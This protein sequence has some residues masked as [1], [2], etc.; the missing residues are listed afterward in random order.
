M[1]TLKLLKS[2]FE[3]GRFP[4]VCV[5]CGKEADQ[6][7]VVKF[8]WTP[9]WILLLWLFGL[10]PF[11]IGY[12]LTIRKMTVPLPVCGRHR[13]HWSAWQGII[14]GGIALAIAIS[15]LGAYVESHWDKTLGDNILLGG[16]CLLGLMFFAIFFISDSG[17]RPEKMTDQ[18]ITL[19]G[20]SDK[21]AQAMGQKQGRIM[22]SQAVGLQ[23][24]KY[25]GGNYG[26]EGGY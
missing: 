4:P 20:V 25:L 16:M 13:G 5:V 21:F 23:T 14:W 12:L 2:D 17:V 24:A 26:R 3:E 15:G 19:K 18:T 1:A 11:F 7:K 9:S 10:L 6:T 22:P 8:S